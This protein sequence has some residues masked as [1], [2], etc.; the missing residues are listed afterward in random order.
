MFLAFERNK[1]KTK[2]GFD[3]VI[4]TAASFSNLRKYSVIT[5]TVAVHSGHSLR[6]KSAR[7]AKILP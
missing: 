6:Y 1:V 2:L 7:T 3:W 5:V 4:F